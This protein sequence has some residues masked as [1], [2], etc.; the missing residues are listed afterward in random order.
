MLVSEI[1]KYGFIPRMFNDGV[2]YHDDYNYMFDKDIEICVWKGSSTQANMGN[3]IGIQKCGYEV[4]D[5]SGAFYWVLGNTNA[6]DTPEY[7]DDV[8]L[9]YNLTKEYWIYPTPTYGA[10][11]SIW[12]DGYSR[13][14]PNDNGDYILAETENLILKFGEAIKRATF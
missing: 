4:I 3:P 14:H 5:W 6:S 13:V 1:K 2:Y 12:C 7:F 9:L 11:L 10:A 8:D